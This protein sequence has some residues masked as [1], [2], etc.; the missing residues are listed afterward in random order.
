M[1]K[2]QEG[3]T[4]FGNIEFS[5]R[6]SENSVEFYDGT[7]LAIAYSYA[8]DSSGCVELDAPQTRRL[9]EVMKEYYEAQ[10]N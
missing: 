2:L 4:G 5:D 7:L 9:Y 6:H 10:D 3:N 1:Y 8:I